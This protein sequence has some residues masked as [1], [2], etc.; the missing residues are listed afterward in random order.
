MCRN[1]RKL[2]AAD[3]Q[4]T[5]L[6]LNDAALQFIRKISGYPKPSESNRKAFE[7]AVRE[8]AKAGRKMFDTLEVRPG[9]VRKAG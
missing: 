7:R 4:P 9:P 2:R 8:V 5:D 1:I 6:E 3:R